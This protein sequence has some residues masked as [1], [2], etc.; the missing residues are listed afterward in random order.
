MADEYISRES[1]TED[2][3]NAALEEA[4][5]DSEYTENYSEDDPDNIG[6]EGLVSIDDD[7]H[8]V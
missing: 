7:G 6:G 8:P 3:T 5:E 4:E 2:L 1:E